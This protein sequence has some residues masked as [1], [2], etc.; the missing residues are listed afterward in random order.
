M[1]ILLTGGGTGGHFYPV[2]A[3]AQE[4]N[5]IA[6]EKKLVELEL[7]YMASKPYDERLLFENNLQYVKVPA[8]KVRRYFSLLNI[9]DVFKTLVGI[10]R[11]VWGIFLMYPDVVFG[12]GGYDSF[13]A[14]L[15]ARLFRIPV[16][17]HESD[18]IPG[19]VNKWAGKFAR[20][21]AITFAETANK[22]PKDKVAQTGN[23]VRRTLFTPQR[24]GA[25]EFLELEENIPVLLFLGGSQGAQI[26]NQHILDALPQLIE[27]YQIIHQTGKNNFEETKQLASVVLEKNRHKER[28]KPFPYFNDLALKMVAGATDLVVSRAG[29]GTIAEIA[30]W[31]IP[32][33][34]VPIPENVSHDQRS[35]AFAYQR[36]GGCIVIEEKNLSASILFSQIE[37]LMENKEERKRMQKGALSFS[38]PNAARVIAEELISIAL[39]HEQ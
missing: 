23:P 10:F 19:K 35:N 11:A 15:A 26:L 9:F 29:T 18:T 25:R 7:Y 32:S 2:I 30:L 22:F 39:E 1:K 6:H 31:G 36:S 5:Q 24:G 8:G 38:K 34:I 17:I 33:I 13:P 14:L 12:K 4:L 16:I 20:R 21:I 28:Y 37:M 27:K 3:V